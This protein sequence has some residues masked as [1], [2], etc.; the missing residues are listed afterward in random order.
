MHD[1]DENSLPEENSFI[2]DDEFTA[3]PERHGCVTTWLI[4][5][6][7]AN[8]VIALIYAFTVN[9]LAA[10]LHTSGLAIAALIILCSINVICAVMLLTWKKIGFYGFVITTV[11]AFILN[12]Y[13]GISP[14]RSIIG[15]LSFAVLY[16]ILQ[17]KRDGISAWSNLK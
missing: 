14:V 2:N 17:I 4:F 16:A 9:K 15:L 13:I 7:I 5:L 6:I 10:T 1:Q 11:L 8:A 3:P 12:L